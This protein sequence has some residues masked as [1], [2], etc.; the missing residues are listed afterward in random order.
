MNGKQIMGSRH[1]R[2]DGTTHVTR[3]KEIARHQ[4]IRAQERVYMHNPTSLRLKARSI[5]E[6]SASL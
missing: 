4:P 1:N 2:S 3:L 5:I 6:P